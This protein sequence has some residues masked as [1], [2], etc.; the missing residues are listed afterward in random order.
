MNEKECVKILRNSELNRK[1][2]YKNILKE[3]QMCVTVKVV[4]L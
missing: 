3:K 1:Y 4:I 2:F